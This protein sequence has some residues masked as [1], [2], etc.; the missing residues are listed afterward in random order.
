ML[1]GG[2]LSFG[3]HATIVVAIALDVAFFD[4]SEPLDAPPVIPVELTTIGPETNQALAGEKDPEQQPLDEATAKDPEPVEP[5]TVAAAAAEPEPPAPLP[6]SNALV[7]ETPEPEPEKPA[8][9]ADRK[10]VV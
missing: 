9:A 2:A 4:G 8:E 6:D 3:L 10:S 7:R 5:P 1:R